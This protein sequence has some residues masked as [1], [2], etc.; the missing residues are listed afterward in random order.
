MHARQARS[1]T[2]LNRKINVSV[3][4]LMNIFDVI[5]II[6]QA[7]K[8]PI[9]PTI[10]GMLAMTITAMAVEKVMTAGSGEIQLMIYSQH[11][12][13]IRQCLLSTIDVGMT[14][15]HGQTGF[16][17]KEI[18]VIVS[19]IPY[20]K[21]YFAQEI[22]KQIDP[23]AFVVVDKVTSVIGRGYTLDKNFAR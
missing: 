17:Q 15:L 21:L 11:N 13:K 4:R 2:V 14:Y 7:Y 8:Q 19:I 5:I 12:E 10:Y 20:Q 23:T 22:V 6:L 18:E 16:E 1:L 9:V 3:A